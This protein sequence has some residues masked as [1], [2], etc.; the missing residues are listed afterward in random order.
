MNPTIMNIVQYLNIAV[1]Y[2]DVLPADIKNDIWSTANR[3]KITE[4]YE[5]MPSFIV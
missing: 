4:E 5:V 2:S 3:R 1:L